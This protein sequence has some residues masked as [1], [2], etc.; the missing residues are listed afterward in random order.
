M[1]HV[2]AKRS[3]NNQG[4]GTLFDRSK[5]AYDKASDTMLCPAG[6][7]LRRQQV[8]KAR[9]QVVYR[10]EAGACAGCPLRA[11]CTTAPR[12]VVNRHLYEDALARMRQRATA[13]AMR[14]RRC[15][16]ERPFAELK[17]RIF[18]YPRFLLRGR[19]GAQIEIS[20]AAM[21]YNLKRMLTV[22]GS[23]SL[24]VALAH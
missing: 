16:A 4:D 8:Q 20:L 21:A 9:R 2:P 3:V 24:R 19:D 14:L 18:G 23:G 17:Y 5:F 22:L 6:Q 1:P 7:R 10:A 12:R 11:R 15:L 13:E